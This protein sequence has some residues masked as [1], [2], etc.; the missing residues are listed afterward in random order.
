MNYDVIW[1]VAL[2]FSG[3][4][5]C[6]Q[7]VSDRLTLFLAPVTFSTLNMDVIRSFE[8]LVYNKKTRGHHIPEDGVRYNFHC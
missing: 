8:T 3:P 5:N 2:G 1:D 6:S 7:Y 4:Q